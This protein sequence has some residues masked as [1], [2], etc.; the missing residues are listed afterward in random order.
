M[1]TKNKRCTVVSVRS[2]WTLCGLTGEGVAVEIR[3]C[4]FIKGIQNLLEL[5]C[6][7]ISSVPKES[8]TP[9]NLQHVL[10]IMGFT[11]A[12]L[13][14]YKQGRFTRQEL[15]ME[16]EPTKA[17][18][19]ILLHH[20]G[21]IFVVKNVCKT[22]KCT[23]CG[24]YYKSNHTC[25]YRRREFY[26][27][28]VNSFS[29]S[30]WEDISFFP[31]G[32]CEGTQRLFI[33]YD[34]ETYTWHGKNGKQLVP[35]LLVFSVSA[36]SPLLS[37]A[38]VKIAHEEKWLEWHGNKNTF[39]VVSPDR[40][41]V[42]NKFRSYRNHLQK[43][44]TDTVWELFKKENIGHLPSLENM[45]FKDLC[46]QKLHGR[47]TFLEIYIVGHNICGFDEIVLAAQVIHDRSEVPKAFRVSRNFMPRNGRIL[48]ND[49]TFALPN[50]RYKKRKDFDAWRC[51]VVEESDLQHQ[52]VKFMVR[53]TFALTHTSLRN[54]AK[55]Y[56]LKV[57]KGSCP[58]TAVN[59]FFMLG[60]YRTDEDGFPEATYWKDHEEYTFNKKTWLLN[61][62]RP[63][64]IVQET[65]D[66][67]ALDVQVTELLVH[68]LCRSYER[69][70]SETVGLPDSRFNV[71]QRPTISSNSHAI[72]RQT[73]YTELNINKPTLDTHLLAPST[74]MYDFV[75]QSIRGGRCYPTYLGILNQPLYVYDIC[76][77]YAS[78]LTHPLPT[79]PPMNPL[80]RGIALTRWQARLDQPAHISYFD[81]ELPPAIFV[82][83]ADPPAE[84]YLDVLPPF[85]SRKGGR[86]VWTNESLRGEVCTSIDAITL[87]NRGWTVNIVPDEKNTVFPQWAC[88]CKRYVEVN[89][90]AKEKADREKNQ[91]MRNIAKLLSNALYGSFATKLD[92]KTVI[93]ADQLEESQA[94]IAQGL[95]NIKCTNFI[96]TDN[97]CAEIMPEFS[98]TY[99]PLAATPDDVSPRNALT[100]EECE[101]PLY[102]PVN[103]AHCVNV[104]YKPIT[105]LDID[106]DDIC[107]HTLERTCPLIENKRYPSHIASFVLAWTRAFISEWATF[108]YADDYGTPLESRSLKSVYGDTDSLF[109]TEEGRK[110][111]ETKGKHRI[112]KNGGKLVFDPTN[113][114]LTW[115]VECETQCQT[116]GADAYSEESVFLAPKLYGL[117]NTVCAQCGNVGNGKLRAKGHAS[118]QLDYNTLLRCY[119]N[120]SQ[121][122]RQTLNTSRLTLKRTIASAQTHVAPFTV[123]ETTLTRRLRPWKDMTLR[124]QHN[125]GNAD[126]YRLL[127][128]S[129]SHPNPRNTHLCSM[130][131]PWNI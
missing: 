73:L 29:A 23:F 98:V 130:E 26:F 10:L 76:G 4:C 50:P 119:L 99:S 30:W 65:L 109:L 46:Q 96:E 69:F 53:D 44:F 38:A 13:W 127:P 33:T 82:I 25:S 32:S 86:L 124:V 8:P 59:E 18:Q 24:S 102:R 72:F 34:V 20:R 115:L 75:R 58:Y 60:S 48:F 93:F 49:I 114:D 62:R 41:Y 70:V 74:H 9:K 80:D 19:P 67:C 15:Q 5:N 95:I 66:Y 3:Y 36:S 64:D 42:G 125:G 68:E 101:A 88:L 31:I 122:A 40:S 14:R 84:E 118:S 52:F 22:N 79:G 108:L 61:G 12:T 43:Y 37:T 7:S 113:P 2:T 89:I 21:K 106:D 63:Y 11:K 1:K 83:D 39:Y 27:H 120:D 105:F 57:E 110:L 78:A 92:N 117:K 77:M 55:A 97:F 17:V 16:C 6:L 47:P 104:K 51:G 85:C 94:L 35:F 87:H 90:G 116:C 129:N 100:D 121:G 107:L 81:N 54:A 131:I 56:N 28:H 123:T 91:T 45:S 103:H 126:G 128:H 112:K 71:L 111:M